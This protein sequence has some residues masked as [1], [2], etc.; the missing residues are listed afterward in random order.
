[1]LLGTNVILGGK[2]TLLERQAKNKRKDQKGKKKQ[3]KQV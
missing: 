2:G 1:M 3:V